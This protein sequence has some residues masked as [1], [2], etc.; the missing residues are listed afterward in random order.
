[1]RSRA[2]V[3]FLILVGGMGIGA[4]TNLSIGAETP[5][6]AVLDSLRTE[7][8]DTRRWD[9]FVVSTDWDST[10]GE[11]VPNPEV[12]LRKR[13]FAL[14]R[15]R[16][17]PVPRWRVDKVEGLTPGLGLQMQWG[18]RPGIRLS[19]GMDR[20]T[21]P[22]R[23]AGEVTVSL[24][25]DATISNGPPP[26]ARTRTG[27]GGRSDNRAPWYFSVTYAERALPFGSN[28]PV[29][30]GAQASLLSL[31]GQNYVQREER[32]TGIGL[33]AGGRVVLDLG[34]TE[35]KDGPLTTALDPLWNT[36]PESW[37]NPAA[38]AIDTKGALLRA[39]ADLGP[40]ITAR[41]GAF[42]GRLGG[43]AEY[44]PLGAE[45]Q[46]ALH[47]PGAELL[48][49]ELWTNA[50]LGRPPR[51]E[52]ADLGGVSSLRAHAPG[53]LVGRASTLLKLDYFLRFDV[54]RR[55]HLPFAR[56]LRLQPTAFVDIGAVWGESDW[57]GSAALRGPTSRDLRTDLGIGIQ[58]NMGY[59]G[60]LGN[61]R[62]DFGWRTDRS[63]DRFRASVSVSP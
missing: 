13:P 54:L 58:R 49:V 31:D 21:A 11:W 19:G 12:D 26:S 38:D 59:P 57:T 47:P 28:R 39:R 33:R 5:L 2:L 44:Y 4:D 18:R 27:G 36:D 35:R 7:T 60:L 40:R 61:L 41:A 34:Y 15:F 56:Q 63:R 37:K 48:Q 8:R 3:L 22:G 20:A 32:T 42:G 24:Q 6:D 14:D 45:A 46:F 23:W 29:Y 51:Q 16:L 62:L 52:L 53:E 50:V 55:L 17:R 1:M 10:A 25:S 30:N 43:E 9:Q